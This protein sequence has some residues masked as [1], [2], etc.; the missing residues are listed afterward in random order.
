M[1]YIM[2]TLVNLWNQ[3][4]FCDIVGNYKNF[5]MIAVAC[6]FLYLAIKKSVAA[7]SPDCARDTI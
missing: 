4:V 5:I 6:V 1:D 3:T 2:D 7:P